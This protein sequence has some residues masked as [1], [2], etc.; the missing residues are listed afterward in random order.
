MYIKAPNGDQRYKEG[1]SFGLPCWRTRAALIGEPGMHRSTPKLGPRA[2][3]RRRNLTPDGPKPYTNTCVMA[4]GG[5]DGCLAGSGVE[6]SSREVSSGHET[7]L[8]VSSV[9]CRTNVGETVA[10]RRDQDLKLFGN[11]C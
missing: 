1:E 8:I 10:P 2:E 3:W 5:F 9:W 6:R 7:W 4:I 11:R